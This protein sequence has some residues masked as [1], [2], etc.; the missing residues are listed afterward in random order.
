M[1][2]T[3]RGKERDFHVKKAQRR[4]ADMREKTFESASNYKH[5]NKK[6]H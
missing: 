4:E 6:T 1:G 3:H 2:K 5:F